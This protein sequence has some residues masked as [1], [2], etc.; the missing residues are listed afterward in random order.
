MLE[1]PPAAFLPY[2]ALSEI[3][4]W[5]K[6]PATGGSR[7]AV[8]ESVSPALLQPTLAHPGQVQPR[9][10]GKANFG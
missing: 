2:L 10:K 7:Q 6:E 9:V 5:S 8:Q 4:A 3:R 1:D